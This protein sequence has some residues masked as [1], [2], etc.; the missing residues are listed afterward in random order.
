MDQEVIVPTPGATYGFPLGGTGSN[1]SIPMSQLDPAAAPSCPIVTVA[2]AGAAARPRTISVRE[3][4]RS[5]RRRG[6]IDRTL[7]DRQGRPHA[8]GAMV[9]QAAVESPGAAA[10]EDGLALIAARV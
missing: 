8:E 1:M 2:P 9:E 6:V 7:V 10:Q 3:I 4:G 5:A